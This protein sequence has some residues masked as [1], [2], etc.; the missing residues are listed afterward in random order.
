M[1][2]FQLVLFTSPGLPTDG[3]TFWFL[4]QVGIG[5][6]TTYPMNWWLIRHGIK[7]VMS[8]PA[9]TARGG[10]QGRPGGVVTARGHKPSGMRWPVPGAAGILAPR[11]QQLSGRWEEIWQQPHNQ[12]ASADLTFQAR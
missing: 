6:V 7:D 2:I 1:A 5:F 8:N 10:E 4:M 12:T 9:D 3:A 11:C